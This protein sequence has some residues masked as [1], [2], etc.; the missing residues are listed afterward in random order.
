MRIAELKTLLQFRQQELVTP[1]DFARERYR[2]AA[3]T[4]ITSG[5]ARLVSLGTSILTVRLT[6]LYLGA[7]RY[8]MWVTITS[9][10]TMLVFADLG[11][12]NG[13]V[14]VV[15]DAKGRGD[16]RAARQATSSAFWLLSTIAAVIA[17]GGLVAY[18]HIDG[19]RIFNV[20]SP[21][22]IAEA[23]PA[24]LIFFLCFV[25][26]LPLG[27]AR[28]THSGL[29]NAFINN[30]WNMLGNL[31]SLCALLVAIYLRAGL[32]M[33]VLSLAGPP[34]LITLINAADLFGRS[35]RELLP[36]LSDF[37]LPSAKYLL[38]IGLMYFL[39]QVSIAVGMQTD[40]IVI[41]QILGAKAVSAYAVPAKLFNIV[42]SFVM[43]LSGAM[44]P[45]YADAMARSDGRWIRKA[46]KWVTLGGTAAA[47]AI[48]AVFVV[49]GNGILEL[50]VGP[51]VRASTLLLAVFGLQSAVASY[52]Q[53]LSF[54]L[55]GIG[56]LRSQA[57]C[58][59][60]MA[61]LNLGLSIYFVRQFGIIGA[62]LGTL[63]AQ[64]AVQV[65]PLTLITR[66]NLRK[67]DSLPSLSMAEV[68]EME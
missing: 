32:P 67:L 36:R 54:L 64:V 50:W 33:L 24:L 52:L 42:T 46:F 22:A 9:V 62:V 11:L 68:P 16:E 26:N 58:A 4:S 25:L 40:N 66:T 39:L 48:A 51:G 23:G 28:G 29:Q 38:Q 61:A 60:S 7:E 8:G 49:F 57:I 43:M 63:I 47:V 31:S 3:L 30:L 44:W 34:V 19:S 6:F 59:V 14:N 15:A 56:V 55:N 12:N 37:S 17:V 45:A 18:P 27:I 65:I 1:E 5:L 35:H 21:R 20:H 53:P 41:A 10:V 13:L 2:R